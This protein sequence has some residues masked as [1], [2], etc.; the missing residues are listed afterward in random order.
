MI[1]YKQGY[2][3]Q[4][5][6][7]FATKVDIYGFLIKTDFIILDKQGN[8]VIQKGYAWDGPTGIP[9]VKEL[10][11]PSL[12]HDALYQLIR[13]KLL[14]ENMKKKADKEF[15]KSAEQKGVSE[16]WQNILAKGVEWLGFL[17]L[18]EERRVFTA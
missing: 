10:M 15:I 3:Y 6:E 12:I 18:G 16:D 11:E 5:Y 2:K 9:D 14:P 4:L 17:G 1:K 8:L 7:T 13:M